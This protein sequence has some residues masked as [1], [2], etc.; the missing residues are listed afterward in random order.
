MW[1][2]NTE[3]D[4]SGCFDTR[5]SPAVYFG[6]NKERPKG[7]VIGR[8][9]SSSRVVNTNSRQGRTSGC[10]PIQAVYSKSSE[11]VL[12]MEAIPI[13]TG[14]PVLFRCMDQC[15]P[16]T[17]WAGALALTDH[18]LQPI[19]VTKHVTITVRR[20]VDTRDKVER[21]KRI[22]RR[23][24][25]LVQT[26]VLGYSVYFFSYR[27]YRCVHSTNYKVTA[28]CFFEITALSVAACIVRHQPRLIPWLAPITLLSQEIDVGSF[29]S[30]LICVAKQN[31][32]SPDRRGL[33]AR[34]QQHA[35]QNADR[36]RASV[37]QMC[38]NDDLTR[39]N[40]LPSWFT[41]ICISSADVN[42]EPRA[43]SIRA[44]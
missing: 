16:H 7:E 13:L 4:R 30:S 8:Q 27:T 36:C 26:L 14:S 2:L 9:P 6:L 18:L 20:S 12:R 37:L 25:S 32:S 21:R 1:G 31:E 19:G 15:G 34:G 28:H 41:H 35:A 17:S 3:N 10:L 11:L 33:Q 5:R 23:E 40:A 43:R 44:C 38:V 39:P 42:D 24:T 29:G 22:L